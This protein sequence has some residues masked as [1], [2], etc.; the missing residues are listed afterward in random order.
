MTEG[1]EKD[2]TKASRGFELPSTGDG[3]DGAMPEGF[4][5]DAT[6]PP[7]G[8]Q[9]WCACSKHKDKE[10][11][12]SEERRVGKECRSRWSTHHQKKKQTTDNGTR[13]ERKESVCSKQTDSIHD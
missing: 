2:A 1:F 11:M 9:V 8:V 4:E 5:K 13:I 3:E 7:A 12:R 6:S 10:E